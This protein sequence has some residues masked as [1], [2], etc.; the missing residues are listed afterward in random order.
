LLGAL[1]EQDD[2]ASL[3]QA[4]LRAAVVDPT[5]AWA[6]S[7]A[8]ATLDKR[9]VRPDALRE[10]VADAARAEQARVEAL[11]KAIAE[12]LEA[13]A[14]GDDVAAGMRLI[15]IG[16]S[17]ESD[18][19]VTGAIAYYEVAARF[20]EGLS[21]RRV[22]VIALRMLGRACGA[23]GDVDRGKSYLR[24]SIEQAA[25][26]GDTSSQIVGL[27]W[28]GNIMFFQG[29]W[30]EAFVEY[31]SARQLCGD[32]FPRLRGQLAMIMGATHRESG[33]LEAA[34]SEMTYAS[35]LWSDFQSA[36]QSVWYNNRGLLAL[37]Q[38]DLAMADTMFRQ[39]LEIAPND[40]DRAMILDNLAELSA[41]HGNLDD[42][43]GYA[44]TAESVALRT[45]SP[46]ALAEIYTRLGKIF[47]LRVD[48]NGV[49]FFE[50]ALELCR[51]RTYPLSEANAYLEYGIF[52]SALGDLE[53]ARSYL[54]RAREL[55][56]QSGLTQLGRSVQEQLAQL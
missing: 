13:S 56:T 12:V 9:L 27:L 25:G 33:D 30:E 42:A 18:E 22:R 11:Y 50:K 5:R 3:R 31:R 46:R 54:E 40:F 16:Q 44:R 38:G 26:A 48:L 52:R 39:A 14:Q 53:E 34:A 17:A 24:T 2:L 1:P 36:D 21:D 19:N 6:R 8:Y 41:R 43:E 15:A 28:L 45:G 49:T 20:S 23:S 7:T 37:A 4:L 35:T 51:G 55:C 10:I 29:L 47:R 32:D